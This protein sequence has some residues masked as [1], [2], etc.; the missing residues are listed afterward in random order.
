MNQDSIKEI[1]Q[2]IKIPVQLGGGIRTLEDIEKWL[3]LGINRVIL[4]S[5]AKKILN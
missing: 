1:L 3:K 5:I 2:E 4:G